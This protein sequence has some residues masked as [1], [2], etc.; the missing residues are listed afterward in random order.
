MRI[1]SGA[2]HTLQTTSASRPGR[3]AVDLKAHPAGACCWN[4]DRSWIRFLDL[5]LGR[6]LL[7]LHYVH[8]GIHRDR[9]HRY[10][11][12]LPRTHVIHPEHEVARLRPE[13]QRR[14][15]TRGDHDDFKGAGWNVGRTIGAA[16][17][18]P[19]PNGYAEDGTAPGN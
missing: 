2:R 5:A 15:Y 16:G 18:S 4:V 8:A 3:S 12:N 7:E 19:S 11:G 14:D 1:L 6:D 17:E 10:R 9:L 13:C